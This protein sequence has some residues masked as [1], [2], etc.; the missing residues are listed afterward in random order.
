VR[1]PP[2]VALDRGAVD[3]RAGAVRGVLYVILA[4]VVVAAVLV[5]A[6]F[7]LFHRGPADAPRHVGRWRRSAGRRT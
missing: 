5:G 6:M 7:S 1:R 2:V 4:L 3:R